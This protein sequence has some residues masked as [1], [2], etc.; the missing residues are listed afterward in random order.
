MGVVVELEVEAEVGTA[1][2]E[3]RSIVT[4]AVEICVVETIVVDK[5]VVPPALTIAYAGS[6][7]G[8]VD[9]E[10]ASMVFVKSWVTLTWTVVAGSDTLTTAVDMTVSVDVWV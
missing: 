4:K 3:V 2:K 6:F 8:V 9:G 7:D 10:E 1:I 5:D